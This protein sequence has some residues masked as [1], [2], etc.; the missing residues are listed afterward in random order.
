[1]RHKPKTYIDIFLDVENVQLCMK[2]TFQR[3]PIYASFSFSSQDFLSWLLHCE[4]V[5][6]ESCIPPKCHQML[7]AVVVLNLACAKEIANVSE[8]RQKLSDGFFSLRN[9]LS[10]VRFRLRFCRQLSKIRLF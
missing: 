9:C 4:M 3:L 1:M 7:Y 2:V 10:E 6:A 5:A 8:L